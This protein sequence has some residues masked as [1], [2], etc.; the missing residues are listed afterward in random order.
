MGLFRPEKR[1]P[2]EDLIVAFQYLKGAYRKDGEGLFIRAY[3][4]RTRGNG[5][6]LAED[7]FRLDIKIK[8]FTVREVRHRNRLPSKVVDAPS[9]KAFKARL[10]GVVNNLVY[11]EVSL[12]IAGRSELGDLKGLFQ[13]KP[14]YDFMFCYKI[15]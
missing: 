9:L 14:F 12:P 7:R 13:S 1:R 5:F 3:S 15:L 6:K 2:W 8:F 4:D 11:R 10:D